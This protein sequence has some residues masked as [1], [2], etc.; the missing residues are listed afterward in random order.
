[1]KNLTAFI[2][3]VLMATHS[4]GQKAV[5]PSTTSEEVEALRKTSKNLH[6][7]AIAMVSIGT[8]LICIGSIVV[9]DSD[10]TSNA[11]AVMLYTGVIL[12]IASIPFTIT[13]YVA[14]KKAKKASLSL[15][16]TSVPKLELAGAMHKNFQPAL[17]LTI[18]L[19]R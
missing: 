12:N 17:T 6:T 5:V 2:A 4:Y 15:S 16:A 10:A 11:G 3:V 9:V 8:A 13:S 1:M 19:H 14:K 18:P 7:T